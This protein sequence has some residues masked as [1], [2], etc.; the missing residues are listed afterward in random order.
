MPYKPLQTPTTLG[1]AIRAQ[2]EFKENEGD[3]QKEREKLAETRHTPP[4][5]RC[6][7]RRGAARCSRPGST[8]TVGKCE[9]DGAD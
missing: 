3:R 4:Y 6:V 2:T 1:E 7:V 8:A 9:Q 5:R